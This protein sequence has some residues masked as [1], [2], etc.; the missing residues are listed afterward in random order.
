MNLIP[1]P[2][3]HYLLPSYGPLVAPGHAAYQGSTVNELV[4]S[5]VLPPPVC[6]SSTNAFPR[7]ANRRCLTTFSLFDRHNLLVA[8]DPRYGRYLTAATIFRGDL[9]AQEVQIA[10]EQLQSKNSS[11][12]VEY[13]LSPVRVLFHGDKWFT[14][15]FLVVC[16][17]SWIPDNVSIT[18]CSVPPVGQKHAGVCLANSVRLLPFP[19]LPFRSSS[20]SLH[21]G[22]LTFR[23]VSGGRDTDIDPRDVETYAEPV[24]SHVQ[25]AGIFARVLPGGDGRDGVHRG[26]EQH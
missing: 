12:F 25:A 2:R 16:G 8:C 13:V 18:M 1:F 14:D 24:C 6:P 26:A 23:P 17:T 4:G 11:V 19:S 5:C 3:M 10:V 15:G 9:S 22:V 7:P 21:P 20:L